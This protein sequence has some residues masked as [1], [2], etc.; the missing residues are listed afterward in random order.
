MIKHGIY[1]VHK[2]PGITSHD[3][4]NQVRKLSG[5]KRVGHAGTLDPFATGVLVVAVGR[6]FTKQI[7]FHVESDKEYLATLKLGYVSTTDDPEGEIQKTTVFKKPTPAEIQKVIKKFVGKI[8]QIPPIY[9]A[10]KIKGKPAHRRVRKGEKVELHPRKVE[11][12]DIVL[13]S[14]EYPLLTITVHCAKGVYIRAL[15]RDIGKE[16]GTGAY[17]TKLIRTR[18]GKFLLSQSVAL[19]QVHLKSNLSM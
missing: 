6:E 15:A 7:N 2:P 11:I 9:S 1:A 10:I 3:V 18:V 14:Y 5:E 12:F 13:E 16:L 4:I 17:L 19:P 8:D